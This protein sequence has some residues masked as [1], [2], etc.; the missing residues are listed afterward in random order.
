MAESSANKTNDD[1]IRA[2]TATIV[3]AYVRKHSV[4]TQQIA[5]I[6][7]AVYGSFRNL[8]GRSD[9]ATAPGKPAVAVKKSITPDYLV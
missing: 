9:A 4:A 7:E 3:A 5:D 1:E 6:I 8:D 2:M